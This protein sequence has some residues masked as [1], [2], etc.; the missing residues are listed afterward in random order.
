MTEVLFY[1]LTESK[2]DAALPP[3]V[4]KSVER[5]WR[6]TVQATSEGMCDRL[7]QLLWTF[8]ADS[9]IPHGVESEEGTAEQP[10]LLTIQ[11]ADTNQSDIRFYVE[12][13]EV[14]DIERYQRVVV[15]FDGHDNDE[16]N[17]ARESWKKLRGGSHSL[18]YWQQGPD[19]RWQKRA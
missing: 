9:F 15:M 10:V 1:H 13:A 4:E 14:A 18:T 12:T 3:L 16:L 2:L 17:H 19:G 7:D 11:S 8:R 6:V 5:G